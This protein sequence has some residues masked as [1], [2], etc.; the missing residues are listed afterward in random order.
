MDDVCAH[1]GKALSAWGGCGGWEDL[2]SGRSRRL[3]QV[4]TRSSNSHWAHGKTQIYC[5]SI[6]SESPSILIP[7]KRVLKHAVLEFSPV[8]CHKR[9][10]LC[11]HITPVQSWFPTKPVKNHQGPVFRYTGLMI[12]F[13]VSLMGFCTLKLLDWTEKINFDILYIYIYIYTIK[14]RDANY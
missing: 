1:E 5:M 7:S 2:R 13:S 12:L 10:T 4:G 11:N 6:V 8:W 9:C 14:V 3:G